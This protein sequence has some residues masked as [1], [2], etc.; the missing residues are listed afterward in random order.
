M[1]AAWRRWRFG[2]RPRRLDWAAGAGF[3]PVLEGLEDR[4]LLSAGDLDPAFG[5]G[6]IVTTNFGTSLDKGQ[7][8][9]VQTDG[10]I[11]VVGN[12]TNGLIFDVAMARYNTDGTL[13]TTFGTAGR[14]GPSAPYDP[15]FAAILQADG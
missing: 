10:K 14:V 3:R 4:T 11:V 8:V 1:L 5:T 13:D 2:V 9:L 12:S 7:S 6:G 15:A